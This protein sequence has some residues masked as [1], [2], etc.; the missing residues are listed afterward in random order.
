MS[1]SLSG[2]VLAEELKQY[3]ITYHPLGIFML[4]QTDLST[5]NLA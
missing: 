4:I 1:T 3:G 5:R 2:A